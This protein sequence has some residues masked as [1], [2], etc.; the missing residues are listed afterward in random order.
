M[1]LAALARR[2][3]PGRHAVCALVRSL[4]WLAVGCPVQATRIAWRRGP[5]ADWGGLTAGGAPSSSNRAMARRSAA[6]RAGEMKVFIA[7][8]FRAGKA[9]GREHGLVGLLPRLALAPHARHHDEHE[10][11]NDDD[12]DEKK[13]VPLLPATPG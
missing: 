4:R 13:H 11:G 12:Q 7:S 3:P 6:S 1:T 2:A 9:P 10:H 5:S 8:P